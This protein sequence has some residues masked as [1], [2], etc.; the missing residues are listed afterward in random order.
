MK[1][2]GKSPVSTYK[3]PIAVYINDVS[4]GPA[5]C[6]RLD[7]SENRSEA[8]TPKKLGASTMEI[9]CY[10]ALHPYPFEHDDICSCMLHRG[11]TIVRIPS[12]LNKPSILPQVQIEAILWG[13]E[14]AQGKLH[15]YCI[16][17]ADSLLN[18]K[19]RSNAVYYHTRIHSQY[20][21]F[22]TILILASC[23]TSGSMV[24]SADRGSKGRWAFNADDVVLTSPSTSV[25]ES[26]AYFISNGFDVWY[27]TTFLDSQVQARFLSFLLA[28]GSIFMAWKD[29]SSAGHI[30]VDDPPL[31]STQCKVNT[32][33]NLTELYEADKKAL[34]LIMKSAQ[35]LDKIYC[36]SSLSQQYG[37]KRLAEGGC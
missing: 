13:L 25:E 15:L 12:W 37:F 26:L 5:D 18:M 24:P 17:R 2:T 29:I 9:H 33:V 31:I 19:I 4:P 35:I 28:T 27:M 23:K 36:H 30:L 3:S 10:K 34:V 7:R 1:S 21:N 20:L 22:F 8:Q 6:K 14:T 16:S 11:F 32:V